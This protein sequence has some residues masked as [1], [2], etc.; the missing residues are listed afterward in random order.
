MIPLSVVVEARE[1]LRVKLDFHDLRR[2]FACW[3]LESSADRHDVWDFL[4]HANSTTTSRY[5]RRTPVRLAQVLITRRT[6]QRCVDGFRVEDS[7]PGASRRRPVPRYERSVVRH[8]Y[9]FAAGNVSVGDPTHETE[10]K[11]LTR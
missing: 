6:L 5:V 4:G 1:R 8:G 9:R 2:E 7:R 3:L 11:K 10:T